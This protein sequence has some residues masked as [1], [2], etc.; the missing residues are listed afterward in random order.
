MTKTKLLLVQLE[1]LKTLSDDKRQRAL[2]GESLDLEAQNDIEVL[3]QEK[4]GVMD[5]IKHLINECDEIE[6]Q[7]D[8]MRKGSG[9]SF[10]LL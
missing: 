2:Q 7:V 6:V 4:D 5:D 8:A 1:V 10:C 9:M 3:I